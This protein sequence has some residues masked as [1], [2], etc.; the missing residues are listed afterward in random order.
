MYK[1]PKRKIRKTGA[2]LQNATKAF[3]HYKPH[4][5]QGT[6]YEVLAKLTKLHAHKNI[7]VK[8]Y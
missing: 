3:F 2:L 8:K 7:Y 6:N 4:P 1:E 5:N